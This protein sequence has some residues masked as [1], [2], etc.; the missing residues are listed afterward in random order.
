M[1]PGTTL[2]LGGARSGKSTA[3]EGIAA[4][5][6]TATDLPVTYVATGLAPT[7]EDTDWATRIAVHRERRPDAW[8]TVEVPDPL[9]LGHQLSAQG[10]VVL[11]DSLGAWVAATDDFDVDVGG[12]CDALTVRAT[13]GWPTVIV[14]EEVGMGVHPVTESGRRF[15]D[16]LGAV[17]QAV[18]GIADRVVLVV[19]GRTLEL[20]RSGLE[21]S[22]LETS[23]LETSGL[24]TS[25]NAL[26]A[27]GDGRPGEP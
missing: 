9:D 2:V 14:T 20:S 24:E 21:T 13:Q 1:A 6:A 10:G 23:G 15:R 8:R 16:T 17:N 19:A 5:Y 3:A 25:S 22:G 11:L 4:Q 26:R 12:L 18:A 7:P 27:P